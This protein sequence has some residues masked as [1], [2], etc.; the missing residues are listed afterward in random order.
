M[1]STGPLTPG[2]DRLTAESR[3]AADDAPSLGPAGTDL[4]EDPGQLLDAARAVVDVRG[5]QPGTQDSLA[6]ED[7]ERHLAGIAREIR[8]NS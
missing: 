7:L 5:A 6:A 3:V 4:G 1:E 8:E 2:H